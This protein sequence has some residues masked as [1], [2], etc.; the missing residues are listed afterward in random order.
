MSSIRGSLVVLLLL[1][2]EV[3]SA[4]GLP[5]EGTVSGALTVNGKKFPLTHVYGRK[6][7][8]WPADAK[9]LGLNDVS[10][11]SCGIVEIIVTNA[12][13]PAATITAIL[14]HD[15]RGSETIRGV[16]F[17][18]DT[19]GD[20]W[21]PLFLL[22]SGSVHGFGMT[23]SSAS[24]DGGTRWKGKV[25][26]KNE[27]VTQVRMFD[28]SFEVPLKIQYARTETET[29]ERIPADRVADEF[30]T[31]LPG[32]WKIERWLGLGCTTASGTLV[33]GERVSPR[34]FRGTFHI[35][36][37]KG[38]KVEEEATIS[39]SGTK[40]HVKGEKVNVPESIWIP[41]VLDLDLWKNLMVGNNATDFV[42]M[43][44]E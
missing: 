10:E 1:V 43:R 31:A 8:A 17:L 34:A 27:D 35:V 28:V 24:I 2:C 37:S 5:S 39:M 36:T 6:R 26:V 11:I 38:D 41:D 9:E 32:Q 15:Y 23:Q 33:V 20:K 21:E 3:A 30:L 44:K 16:H 4:A 19:A 12:A 18:I 29:A 22:E 42:V 7:E 40:V 14:Q 25:S 13:L